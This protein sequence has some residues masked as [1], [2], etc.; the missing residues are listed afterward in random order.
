[1][2]EVNNSDINETVLSGMIFNLALYSKNDISYI[3]SIE[4]LTE[5]RQYIRGS[6]WS[7]EKIVA[8][9]DYGIKYEKHDIESELLNPLDLERF[10]DDCKARYS[11]KLSNVVDGFGNLGIS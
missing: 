2:P 8:N 6:T 10:I 4:D 11:I 7:N 5:D 1:M 3:K 9:Q